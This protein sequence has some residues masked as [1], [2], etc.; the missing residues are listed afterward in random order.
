MNSDETPLRALRDDVYADLYRL[1]GRYRRD[2]SGM[3]GV[4]LALMDL[5]DGNLRRAISG[6][7][8]EEL[9]DHD[10]WAITGQLFAG[11]SKND[12][13]ETSYFNPGRDA[14]VSGELEL[15]YTLPL[16]YR[17]SFVQTLSLGSSSYWQED[18]GSDSTWAV[19][20][21][22]GWEFEPNVIFEYG[23]SR[24]KSVY[25]G[26]PEYGNFI[27]AGVEWRFL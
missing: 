12:E 2:E 10:E 16:G 19:G 4:G 24:Q 25:D 20:Y 22:H 6:Y 23:F 9:Y 7:W 8:T 15:G 17:K 14:S 26:V 13:I 27:T 1:E 3:G 21:R 18:Y 5:E 11:A